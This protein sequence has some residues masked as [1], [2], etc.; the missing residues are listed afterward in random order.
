[1]AIDLRDFEKGDPLDSSVDYGKALKKLQKR[2]ERLQAAHVR[3][4]ARTIILF[5]GWDAGGKSGVI[6]RLTAELDPRH[7]AV[8]PIAAPTGEEKRHHF[9]WRFWQR[10]PGDG[11]IH[12]FDRSWYG[13]VLVERVEGLCTAV[14][15]ERGYDEI[16]AFE[17]QQIEA[18]T[19]L[20]KLFLH[21]TQAFQDDQLAE[22]L[23]D[24]WKRWKT[25]A[26]D[27]RNRARRP[28]YLAA[29]A[30]MFERTDTVWAPWTVIDGND[31][32]AARIKALTHIV[33]HMEARLDMTPPDAD[34]DLVKLAEKALK[35][36]LAI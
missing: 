35:R 2:L 29:M 3:Q 24:P 14:E 32:R 12:I 20:I 36:K 31:R 21:V 34:P 13:R 33:D 4:G 9:L 10:L 28:D 27:Y 30:D 23:E 6:K 15:W 11:N 22:R 19:T 8:W 26:D 18:G 17:H 16:N 5:E 1:M 7:L 25:D